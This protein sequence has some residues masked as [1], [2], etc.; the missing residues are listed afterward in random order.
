[1]NILNVLGYIKKRIEE[2]SKTIEYYEKLD[3]E[4]GFSIEEHVAYE[5]YVSRYD[6]LCKIVDYIENE[7][8]ELLNEM[9]K[10]GK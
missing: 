8:N 10:R 7:L 9:E 3:C 6:E 2:L 1:M 5:N 4:V